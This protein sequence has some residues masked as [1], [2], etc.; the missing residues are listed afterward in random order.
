M[1]T[2]HS[3]WSQ[4]DSGIL[5]PVGRVSDATVRSRTDILEILARAKEI[6]QVYADAAV[7]LPET[8]YLGRLVQNATELWENLSLDYR[9]RLNYKTFFQATHLDRIADAVLPLG[10][11]ANNVTYL[12]AL[13]SGSLNF[14][15]RE[16]SRAKD[17]FW[18]LEVWSRLLRRNADAHL[19]DPPD[20]VVNYDN[21]CIGIA[22]KKL[23]SERHVQNVL[24][25]AVRQ[26]ERDF[27]FGIV[28]LN[29]DDLLPGDVVLK[30][31]STNAVAE[32]LL[33]ANNRFLHNH[34]RHFR[35]YLAKGRL[36]SAIVSTSILADVPAER[37]QFRNTYQWTV[38]TIPG[39]DARYQEPL[40]KFYRTVMSRPR[41]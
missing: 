15:A 35:K 23:Y 18:E 11:I 24:S 19:E 38:W 20:V 33:H 1:S 22:C 12:K 39:L 5:I 32:G 26:I 14:F 37:P 27:D 6:A 8:S 2:S 25:E 36:I 9:E 16:P 13:L 3:I 21:F 28:G 10:G 4:S 29:L 17:I 34:E 7:P 30:R 31:D 40:N 41:Q